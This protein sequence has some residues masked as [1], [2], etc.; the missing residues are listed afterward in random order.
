MRRTIDQAVVDQGIRLTVIGVGTAFAL[1]IALTLIM[2]CMATVVGFTTR[3]AS[4][5]R[6]VP[7][8]EAQEKALAAVV[9]VNAL[10]ARRGD[11]TIKEFQ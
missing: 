1:L 6:S 5:M 3:R 9:A 8:H 4:S 11:P 2:Y 7:P 10:L